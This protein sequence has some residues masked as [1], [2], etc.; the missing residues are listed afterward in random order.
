MAMWVCPHCNKECLDYGEIQLENDWC[1]FPRTCSNCGTE[2]LERY[3]M[4]YERQEVIKEWK[5][6]EEEESN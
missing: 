4:D 2:W 6:K 3:V 1:Y 5:T